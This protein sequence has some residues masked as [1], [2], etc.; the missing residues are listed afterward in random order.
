MPCLHAQA[1]ARAAS[2][3]AYLRRHPEFIEGPQYVDKYVQLL[4]RALALVKN[5]VV[6]YLEQAARLSGE[7]PV[8]EGRLETSEIY[9]RFRSVSHRVNAGVA[10]MRKYVSAA[11]LVKTLLSDFR[12]LYFEKR[13][14]LL[15]PA[16]RSHLEAMS[17]QREITAMIRFGAAFLVRVGQLETQLYDACLG[18]E[19]EQVQ[20]QNQQQRETA[21]SSSNGTDEAKESS[22]PRGEEGGG[23]RG[24]QQ[25]EEG[26]EEE[27]EAKRELDLQREEEAAE[28]EEG[29]AGLYG[30]L[31]QLCSELHKHLRPRV[32]HGTDMD[33]LC[34]LVSVIREEIVEEQR[35]R[36]GLS[37]INP[38]ATAA[39]GAGAGHEG[40]G[41]GGGEA[42]IETILM[43]ASLVQDSQE[44]LIYM[45]TKVIQ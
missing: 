31:L 7:K 32:Y 4:S 21:A 41:G 22:S 19:E 38:V 6:E 15:R 34:E 23:G 29:R 26:Q 35:G 40:D 39:A 44:R 3:M 20:V 45:A 28:V 14:A 11:P 13:L 18:P 25:E 1:L 37:Q 33:T 9:S 2:A 24:N 42:A 43:K 5:Q 12:Q 8:V 16:V 27:E 10:L 17:K 30:M 36:H